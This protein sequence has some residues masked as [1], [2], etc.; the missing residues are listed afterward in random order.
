[1]LKLEKQFAQEDKDKEERKM[2]LKMKWKTC[3]RKKKAICETVQ[4]LS[5]LWKAV[6]MKLWK[7]LN[8]TIVKIL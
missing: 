8:M 6:I 7:S 5:S 3:R 4:C 2:T 1:M